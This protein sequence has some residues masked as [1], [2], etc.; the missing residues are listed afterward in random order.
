MQLGGSV[1]LIDVIAYTRIS[2]EFMEIAQE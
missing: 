1:E 2:S